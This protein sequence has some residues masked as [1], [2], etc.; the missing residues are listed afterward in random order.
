MPIASGASEE[1]VAIVT[2]GSFPSGRQVARA[3]ARWDWPIVLV[4][5]ECQRAVEAAV[6]EILQADG[7]VV[8]VRADLGDDFDV[9]RLFAESS[10]TFG[11][12]DVVAHTTTETASL[13]LQHAARHVRRRGAIVATHAAEG[14]APSVARELRER[15]IRVGRVLPGEVLEFLDVWRRR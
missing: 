1:V 6:A 2:G 4:Y 12:V 14:V 8:A 15:D 13:L 10:A 5:L 7:N 3:L 11:G 9:A